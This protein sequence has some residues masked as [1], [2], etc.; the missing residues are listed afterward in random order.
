MDNLYI[1]TAHGEDLKPSA[2]SHGSRSHMLIIALVVIVVV[3]LGSFLL[4]GNGMRSVTGSHI[5][6]D[7]FS[8][9]SNTGKPLSAQLR[10]DSTFEIEMEGAK[11]DMLS[12]NPRKELYVDGKLF[13]LGKPS[14]I[15]LRIADYTGTFN[16]NNAQVT[17]EGTGD[18]MMINQIDL[19]SEKDTSLRVKELP[20]S[21]GSV[22]NFSTK[23]VQIDGVSG[24]VQVSD[25]SKCTLRG[26][27]LEIGSFTGS[28]SIQVGA[29]KLN[30]AGTEVVC[31]SQG[32]RTEVS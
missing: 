11:V 17:L 32:V 4:T 7:T 27:T 15:Q 16:T 2:L 19:I 24:T 13:E 23:N 1:I 29:L 21:S 5:I 26:G 3:A 20:I 14:Q 9:S 6:G 31:I 25:V 18:D 8:T 12:Q 28:L 30:G 10:L 22:S